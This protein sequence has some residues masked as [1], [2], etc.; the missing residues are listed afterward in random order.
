MKERTIL[1]TAASGNA[2]RNVVEALLTKDF[3]VAAT[4]RDPDK[5]SLLSACRATCIRCK[6]PCGL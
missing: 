4:S 1:V 5:L 2:G 3:N 6:R